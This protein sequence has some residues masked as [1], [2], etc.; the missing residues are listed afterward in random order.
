MGLLAVRHVVLTACVVCLS[1]G[2]ALADPGGSVTAADFA[3]GTW[4]LE[5]FGAYYT[6]MEHGLGL[7]VHF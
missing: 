3:R 7:Q 6:D 5:P 4:T 2:V 1:S